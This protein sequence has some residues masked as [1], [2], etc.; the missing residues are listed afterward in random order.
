MADYT[1]WVRQAQSGT[2]AARRDAF[3]HL[4]QAFQN[5]VYRC[6]YSRLQDAQLAEDAAQEA[7]LTAY[8]R[9][10][11][12]QDARAFP[13]WLRRIAWNKADHIQRRQGPPVADL[14]TGAFA[15]LSS[16]TPEAQ[17][18]RSELRQR[19]R[20]AVTALP[21]GQ[22]DLT[23]EF[24]FQGE[25]QRAISERLNLPLSTVKKRLQYARAQLRGLIAGFNESFDSAMPQDPQPQRQVQPVTLQRRIPRQ[26]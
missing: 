12:L 23:R 3:D 11:Q 13:A 25:S 6:A 9:I 8:Q 26:P 17:L 5:M 1:Q 16:P 20:A 19:V 7:F 21:A 10:P 15:A 2:A 22:R 18:E 4:V 14:D 24:Y